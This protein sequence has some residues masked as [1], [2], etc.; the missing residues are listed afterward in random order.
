MGTDMQRNRTRKGFTLIEMLVVIGIIAALASAMLGAYMSMTRRAA[1]A[2]AAAVVSDAATALASIISD[3]GVWPERLEQEAKG[4]DG[5]LNEQ[6][7]T[8]L[9]GKLALSHQTQKS[10]AGTEKKVLTGADRFGVVT[11]WAA[12]VLKNPIASL[13]SPVPPASR[14]VKDHVLHYALDLDG[15]GLTLANVGGER[16][17]IR[18]S[19]AVWCI[20]AGGGKNGAIWPYSEGVRHGDIYSWTP[21]QVK[22]SK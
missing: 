15:D 8:V 17:E 20:G 21:K 7:A 5:R 2:A 14:P 6:V 1:R 4:G 16:L 9:I 22:S 18:A 12:K 19:A 10:S 13:K 3:K 11:S